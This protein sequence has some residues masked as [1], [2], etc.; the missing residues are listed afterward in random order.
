RQ[1]EAFTFES[2]I[3]KISDLRVDMQLPGI[4]TNITAFGAFVD[5]GVHQDGLVHIS[6]MANRF[7]KDPSKV[8]KV[9]QKVNVRVIDVDLQRNRIALSMQSKPATEKQKKKLV[10]KKPPVKKIKPVKSRPNRPF[11]NPFADLLGG[12]DIEK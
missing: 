9:H 4:I 1:F 11:H 2:G 12:K 7:V 6:K 8:V 5:I 3:E 10:S